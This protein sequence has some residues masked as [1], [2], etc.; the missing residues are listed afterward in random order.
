LTI[1]N[2]NVRSKHL[3]ELESNLG[4]IL[5]HFEE[6]IWPRRIAV[7]IAGTL[8]VYTV[9][10]KEEALARFKQANLLDCRISAFPDH[11]AFAGLN[12]QPLTLFS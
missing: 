3:E 1:P 6:P 2:P 7:L 9:Y 12:R 11:V 8:K 4:F 5:S 10:G